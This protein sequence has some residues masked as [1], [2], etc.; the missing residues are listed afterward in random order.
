[1]E[2]SPALLFAV[3]VDR[4]QADCRR[5]SVVMLLSG[6]AGPGAVLVHFAHWAIGA[7][8]DKPHSAGHDSLPF[9]AAVE[10]DRTY[11]ELIFPTQTSI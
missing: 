7:E 9:L 6:P 8:H 3:R 4:E 10:A 11:T 5:P 1:V 2:V